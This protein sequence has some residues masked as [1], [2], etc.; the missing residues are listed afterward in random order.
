MAGLD[1][2]DH[3]CAEV[4]LLMLH[5]PYE[6]ERHPV[7]IN[8]T[9]VHAATLLHPSVPQPDGGRMYRCLTEFPDRSPG[10]VMP[11]STLTH[12]LN[13]GRLWGAVGDWERVTDAVVALAR[14]DRCDAMPLGLPQ[15]S[16][17]LLAGGPHTT[18][19]MHHPDGTSTEYGGTDRLE[20]LRELEGHVRGFVARAPF[21]PGDDLVTPAPFAGPRPYRP[22]RPESHGWR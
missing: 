20:R 2:G 6:E 18:L 7:P 14:A 9:I 22:Y 5:E 16:A 13:G 11:L 15:V 1:D 3:V 21:W 19:T 8:A 12:E 17:A 10:C 4:Y